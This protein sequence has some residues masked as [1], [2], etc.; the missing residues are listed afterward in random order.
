MLT[1]DKHFLRPKNLRFS[2][3]TNHIKTRWQQKLEYCV[4]HMQ[5]L[6]LILDV[7]ILFLKIKKLLKRKE[8]PQLQLYQGNI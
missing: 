5:H 1:F 2:S 3:R 4:R 7:R 6:S 8:L